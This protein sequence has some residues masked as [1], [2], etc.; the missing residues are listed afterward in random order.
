MVK[1][2]ALGLYVTIVHKMQRYLDALS[3]NIKILYI[4]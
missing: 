2:Y 1:I 4:I 3:K